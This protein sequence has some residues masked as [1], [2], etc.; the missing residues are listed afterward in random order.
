MKKNIRFILFVLALVIGST[1]AWAQESNDEITDITV[2]GPTDLGDEVSW[3]F[4]MPGYNVKAEVIYEEPVTVSDYFPAGMSTYYSD[5]NLALLEAND[6]LKFYTVTGVSETTVELTEIT[7]KQFPANTPLIVS[8]ESGETI[9]ATFFNGFTDDQKESIT[10]LWNSDLGTKK[11]YEGFKG[12]AE[13]LTALKM[14]ANKLYYGFTGHDFAIITSD[15]GVYA[16]RCWL[17]IDKNTPGLSD[18]PKLGIRNSDGFEIFY[19]SMAEGYDA[20]AASFAVSWPDPIDQQEIDVTEYFA[21]SNLASAPAGVTVSVKVTPAEGYKVDAVSGTT[22]IRTVDMRARRR[23]G[24]DSPQ[25][26]VGFEVKD[27]GNGLWTFTMP[28]ANVMLTVTYSEILPAKTVEASWI[29]IADGSYIYNGQAIEPKVTVKDGETDVTTSFNVSYSNNTDAGQATVTVTAL[30][31]QTA[32]TGSASKSFTI[33]PKALTITSES[34]TKEYDGKPL[35]ASGYTADGLVSGDRVASVKIEGSQTDVGSSKNTISDAKIV[36]AAGKDV[37]ANYVI[38]YVPGTLTVTEGVS[39]GGGG[40]DGGDYIRPDDKINYTDKITLIAQSAS[41]QYDGKSLMRPG[42]V[43]VYGLPPVYTIQ[44]TATGSQ[45]DVGK[46]DNV[47][48]SYKIYNPLEEDVTTHFTNVECVNGVLEVTPALLTITTGSATK[49]WDGEPLTCDKVTITCSNDRHTIT[50]TA[51]GSQTEVGSSENTYSIDWGSEKKGNYTIT[52]NLGTLTVTARA[53][54]IVITITAASQS[55]TYDGDAHSNN[56]V[57]VT[58]GSLLAG[59]ALVA[60]ATGSVKDVADTQTGNNPIAEGYKVMHGETD[61]TANY[62]IT[63]EA[64]TLTILP[65]EVNVTADD[66][67]MTYG[68]MF[69]PTLT[70]TADKLIDND[71]YSGS[72]ER[73]P[74]NDA[75]KYMILQGTLTAGNNYKINF[76]EGTFTIKPAVLTG[77]K[78]EG[79]SGYYDGEPHTVSITAAQG[80]EPTILFMDND[81]NYTLTESPSFKDVGIYLVHYQISKKNYETLEGSVD[82]VIKKRPINVKADDITINYGDAEPALTYTADALC[83]DDKFSGSLEREAGTAVGEY[84]ISR[85]SLSAGNNYNIKFTPGKLTIKA[86][87]I[88]GVE[89]KGWSGVFDGLSHTVSVTIPDGATILFKDSK[90]EYSLTEAPSFNTIGTHKVE[91]KV[92]KAYCDDVIGSATVEILPAI[93]IGEEGQVIIGDKVYTSLS[94]IAKE[95]LGNAIPDNLVIGLD[96]LAQDL[97]TEDINNLINR[98][99]VS[100]TYQL[101]ITKGKDVIL[102]L[103][104]AKA[105]QIVKLVYTGDITLDA[106]SILAYLGDIKAR[107]LVRTRSGDGGE[108]PIESGAEYVVLEDCD[109]FFTLHTEEEAVQISQITVTQGD[110]SAI[111]LLLQDADGT[112]TWYDLQGRKINQPTKKGLYIKDGRKVVIK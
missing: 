79:W 41:K 51:T 112:D 22:W 102:G 81:G 17:E 72:L 49:V 3:T 92:S 84:V 61:V 9:T 111:R 71:K 64:G 15:E 38:T 97:T 77:V 46:T 95:V 23:S 78:I 100:E 108:M 106:Q 110:P 11:V 24:D 86:I 26:G 99:V 52:E 62:T 6:K 44:A 88:S 55:W 104:K 50:V 12:T 53:E 20:H 76:T 16:H 107:A 2:E 101:Q 69:E 39:P 48:S 96:G 47:V 5:K 89:V 56:T 43:L 103:V 29:T 35:T 82:I 73:E 75:R 98:I 85:G 83:G 7:H 34:G 33:A 4:T 10:A 91:Y 68:D 30:S 57:T 74:G 14:S 36:N 42:D 18:A 66:K 67:T 80:Q 70:Y 105:G 94:D 59:D 19:V 63:T 40:D 8:N 25:L 65:K 45:T 58:S 37:T 32:Y 109:I 60:T 28:E 93:V 27:E 87:A 13:D 54:K 1:G 31:N 90:G 21:V